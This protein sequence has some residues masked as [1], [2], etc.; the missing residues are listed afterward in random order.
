[1]TH[2][3]Y[4]NSHDNFISLELS[5]TYGIYI[6][7]NPTFDPSSSFETL[8][9]WHGTTVDVIDIQSKATKVVLKGHCT[10]EAAVRSLAKY[11]ITN[12]NWNTDE[13]E[14]YL[15]KD[16]SKRWKIFALDFSYEHSHPGMP[17]LFTLTLTLGEIGAEGYVL[18]SKT[19][20]IS[21]PTSV[22]SI[23][24]TGDQ[25]S[26]YELIK[27]IGTYS[28]GSNLLEPTVTQADLL[29]Y[30]DVADVLLDTAFFEFYSN[31]TAKHTYDESFVTSNGFTRN[32]NTSTNVT[33][34]DST[35]PHHLIIAAS[36][37]LQYK[38]QLIHPLLNDPELVLTASD[39]VGTPVLEV[40]S[41]GEV[42]WECEK[43]IIA[44]TLV[45][46]NLTKL[47]GYSEFY[48]RITTDASSSLKLSYLKL[49]SYH[50]YSGQKPIL[51]L[52][53]GSV[54][55]QLNISFSGGALNYEIN[56]RD[57]WSV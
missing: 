11:H 29:Y 9:P 51:Y 48:F 12:Y 49:I 20:S 52:R 3:Y 47:S 2:T 31:Y 57:K 46:Y 42:W 37:T 26:Y 50:N 22:A 34:S 17:Y 7:E 24:N 21:S 16:L 56:Y 27:I 53:S 54:S 30:I 41:D 25:D 8:S 35:D 40:S 44:G 43:S 36:A 1:L 45:K 13:D 10:T 19:G 4:L 6:T 38:F 55:E 33:W 5:P 39:V 28:G 18:T 15:V 32:V 14:M 23:V